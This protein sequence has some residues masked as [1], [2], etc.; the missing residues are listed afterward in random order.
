MRARGRVLG[1][2][3][4]V[5]KSGQQFAEEEVVLL[6]AIADQVGVAVENGFLYQQAEQLAVMQERSRLA[7]EL[8]DS[9]TQ[10]LYSLIV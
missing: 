2:L 8:H 3:S 10:S 6:D 9:V 1:V 7:R 5:G 4:V